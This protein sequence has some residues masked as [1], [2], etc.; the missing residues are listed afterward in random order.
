MPNTNTAAINA[1]QHYLGQ[2]RTAG[3]SHVTIRPGVLDRLLNRGKAIA[4]VA[5]AEPPSPR[6]ESAASHTPPSAAVSMPLRSNT[7]ASPA[8]SFTRAASATPL[9]DISTISLDQLAGDTKTEKLASLARL[10]EASPEARAL[11]T[12]RDRMVFAVGTPNADIMFVGEAPGAEEERLQ[13][14]FV[15][16]AGQ[17][18]SSIINAMGLQRAD[19]YISNICKFRPAMENQGMSNRQPTP[20]EMRS[21]LAYIL[22][23]IAIVKPKVI[24][25]LGA[26]AATGLGIT[27][28]VTKLRGRFY[29][30][31]DIPT[32]VT[33]HPS[34]LLRE[35][36][37]AG[38]GIV[39]KRQVW[40]D[41]LQ[42]M[43]KVG[44]P[45]SE[46]QRNFFRR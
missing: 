9:A 18:L 28:P 21:C 25:A 31:N 40:E 34:Y 30:V 4:S 13:E 7:P 38:K 20:V 8:K 29:Q 15:G 16:P 17:K 36:K 19:V 6:R 26:T 46:K 3:K 22:T 11:G 41:M 2:L 37:F 24:V 10:A 35:E 5:P 32:M 27:G 44:L 23:E 33:F 42:V 14:P 12:L 45:I 1:L 39:A 43:D